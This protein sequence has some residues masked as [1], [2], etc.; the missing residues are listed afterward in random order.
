LG[1]S[2]LTSTGE[3]TRMAAKA[4]MNTSMVALQCE[5]A[6][7]TRKVAKLEKRM[8]TVEKVL[9]AWMT[10][11]VKIQGVSHLLECAKRNDQKRACTCGSEPLRSGSTRKGRQQ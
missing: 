7:L 11:M 2:A 1:T 8:A 3:V 6:T 5:N 4:P 10:G 9:F